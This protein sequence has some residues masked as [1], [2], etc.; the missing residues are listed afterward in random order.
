MNQELISKIDGWFE[1]HRENLIEDLKRIV[2]IPSVS[3]TWKEGCGVSLQEHGG[4]FGWECKKALEEMLLIGR[5]HGFDTENY[6]DYVGSI[7]VK[8]SDMSNTIGFWNHLD[9]VPVGSGWSQ[10]PFEPTEKDG[11]LI[12]R[13]V[14]DNKGP[15]VGMLYLMQCI[16]ELGIE[17]KHNLRLFVGC[18]EE[19]G[20]EDMIYYTKN[21]PCP[22]LSLIPDCG[23]PVCYGEKG[24]IEGQFVLNNEIS[25]DIISISGGNASN[26]IPD[27]AEISLVRKDGLLECIAAEKAKKQAELITVEE[28]DDSI[29]IEASGT[30]C[31]SAFPQGSR[32]A[33]HE[34]AAFL[35]DSEFLCEAD[36]KQFA[37][38]EMG[39][40]EYYGETEG[41]DF[42]DEIS[43]KTTCAG[44]VLRLEG[45]VMTLNLN[46]RY[47]ITADSE[48]MI[49]RLGTYAA[50]Y[51]AYWRLERDSKPGYFP[52]EHPAVSFLTDLFNEW[53]EQEKEAFVMGGGTYA[54]K[55]P[56]AFAYGLSGMVETDEEKALKKTLFRPGTGGA[57]EPDEALYLRTYFEGLKF[58]TL[59]MIELDQVI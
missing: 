44:T 2:R 54:R 39:T 7:G 53:S 31:H 14:G 10:D 29:K 24:I 19:T 43:G 55:L 56:N 35:M 30:S 50:E 13:G 40:R 49:E 33:I 58:Y 28:L 18:N 5:E 27:Y 37:F 25:A 23:F 8:G 4:P 59:A 34:L 16:R 11:F 42:E 15:A 57:H 22:K 20:M 36:R 38:L 9:V 1:E 52:K 21:Y 17:M 6:E 41:I 26:I 3:D 32:N 45:R 48:K 51:G 47:S 12:A 46:I